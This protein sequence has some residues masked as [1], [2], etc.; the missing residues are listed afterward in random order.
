[1]PRRLP[2]EGHPG[3]HIGDDGSVFSEFSQRMLKS[4]ACSNGYR[5]IHLG[6]GRPHL[7]HRLVATAF[8]PNPEGKPHVNHR[9]ADRTNNVPSNLEWVTPSENHLHAHRLPNRKAH[10]LSRAVMVGGELVFEDM[11]DAAE[12]LRV[13]PGSVASAA[14]RNHRC[15]GKEIRYVG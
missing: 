15:K 3:H 14:S 4:Q 6:R 13:V 11:C 12:H 5:F 9:D 1:M 7:V 8:V 10:G 2:I